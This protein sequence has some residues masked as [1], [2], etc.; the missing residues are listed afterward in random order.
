MNKSTLFFF[1]LL[2]VLLFSSCATRKDLVYLRDMEELKEYPVFQKY[3]AVIHRDDRLSIT[4]SCKN[5][6][7]TLPFNIPGSS[8][9]SI[10]PDGN[11]STTVPT[12]NAADNANKGYLVDVNGEIDFPVLGKLKVEGRTRGQVT[13]MIKQRLID[14]DLIKDPIVMVN[15]LNFK[16]TVLGEVG[17]PN[18]YDITG[19]RITLLEAIAKAGDV[20]DDGRVDRVAVIR[21]YGNK[22]RILFHDLRSKD[23]FN[24]PCY[25]L[26]QNDIVYVEPS[27]AK[28]RDNAQRTFSTFSMILSFVTTITSL[29]VLAVK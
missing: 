24:S 16:I 15:F 21:E 26:Q 14:E 11:I 1:L 4:V 29:V 3:E 12:G 13:E 9:Y 2:T 20:T 27:A 17:S 10:G 25:Y 5:P 19:D 28:T 23:V 7:L 6:E 18:T 8:N 22:R